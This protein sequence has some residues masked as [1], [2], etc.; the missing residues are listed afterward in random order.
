V[1]F[2]LGWL[3]LGP[4][5]RYLQVLD[6]PEGTE[7]DAHVVLAGISLGSI[8]N[9][10]R[11]VYRAP[12]LVTVPLPGL[13]RDADRILDVVD[14]CPDDP[15][16]WDDDEDYDG[17]P[18]ERDNDGDGVINT[19]DPCP[20]QA[21]DRDGFQDEDG[22]PDP[23]NDGDGVLDPD[24]LCP[25]EAGPRESAGCPVRDRDGDGIT[26]DVDEC[27]DV[28]GNPP[29]GCP[30]R[31]LVVKTDTAIEIKD[32]ILFE[33]AKA[34]IKG[35]T[36][37]AILDQVAAVMKSNPGIAIRVEGHTD[38][39]AGPIFNQKLSQARAEAVRQALI[40]RGIAPARLE[41]VGYGESRPIATGKTKK[42]LA[43]NRRVEFL[44][45]HT[46]PPEPPPLAPSP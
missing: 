42:G 16:D 41:A 36:S 34:K 21:E 44:I 1:K 5:L 35:K 7:G 32:K 10:D 26:D 31:V 40:T 28:P 23:D 24:D 22:C 17:C 9:T 43:A 30:E 39:R 38:E 2:D 15:E 20:D 14:K 13:D 4:T 33:T 29:T 6:G 3:A 12:E 18:E 45:L 25:L 37:F 27:P 46:E 8:S 19:A 11:P